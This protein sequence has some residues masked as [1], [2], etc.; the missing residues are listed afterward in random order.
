[1]SKKNPSH[2]SLDVPNPPPGDGGTLW[3]EVKARSSRPTPA[4]VV[5]FPLAAADGHPVAR[6]SVSQSILQLVKTLLPRPPLSLGGHFC[7]STTAKK[8]DSVLM[9]ANAAVTSAD[10]DGEQS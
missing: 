1:M 3:P 4:Q 6:Q 5:R 7:H 9:S 8:P 2:G 10:D